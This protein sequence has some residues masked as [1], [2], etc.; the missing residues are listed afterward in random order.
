M[1]EIHRVLKTNGEVKYTLISGIPKHS[2]ILKEIARVFQKLQY[3]G[4][5]KVRGE[6]IR[7]N[8]NLRKKIQK[9]LKSQ[10]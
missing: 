3:N 2:K 1:K 5:A 10:K 8:V 6:N 4:A 9:F 7:F